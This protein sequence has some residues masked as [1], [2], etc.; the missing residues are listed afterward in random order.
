L[1]A[2]AV[3]GE[4]NE[5]YTMWQEQVILAIQLC[6]EMDRWSLVGHKTK[7]VIERLFEASK[8]ST[9]IPFVEQLANLDSGDVSMRAPFFGGNWNDIM[10]DEYFMGLG[11]G[12]LVWQR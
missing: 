8:P 4:E 11:T 6:G 10:G 5:T 9:E 2:L 12:P 1:I 3:E 7:E